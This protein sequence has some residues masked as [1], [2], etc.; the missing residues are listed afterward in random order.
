MK[1]LSKKLRLDRETVRR[2]DPR[3][4]AAAALANA[5]GGYQNVDNVGIVWTGC[6][7]ACTEC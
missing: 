5:R 7:S 6:D 4:V 3:E 1:K 2:L